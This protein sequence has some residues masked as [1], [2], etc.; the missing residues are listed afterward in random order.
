[1]CFDIDSK[2]ESQ[3]GRHVVQGQAICHCLC[4]REWSR[5]EHQSGKDCILAGAEQDEGMHMCCAVV[6][7]V[8]LGWF[9]AKQQVKSQ[10][11][12]FCWQFL[13]VH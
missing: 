2:A 11:F 7:L 10:P 8:E 4:G 1:M 13:F 3:S 6:C 5:E 9:Y 12:P